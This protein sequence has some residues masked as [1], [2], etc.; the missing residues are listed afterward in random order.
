M[1]IPGTD[2][3]AI[4][5]DLY[6]PECT[7]SNVVH[8]DIRYTS[9]LM[10]KRQFMPVHTHKI[11]GY[12]GQKGYWSNWNIQKCTSCF[13][14]LFINFFL[15]KINFYRDQNV[16]RINDSWLSASSSDVSH[17][18]HTPFPAS[19]KVL[20]MVSSQGHVMPPHFFQ[21]DLYLNSK[22]IENQACNPA[23]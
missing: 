4:A 7:I 15:Q 8:V 9:Y 6:V 18:I 11:N 16:S 10:R 20:R 5:R 2:M 17:I 1:P 21:Q 3:R 12:S 22:P 14:F 23:L 13:I 19:V